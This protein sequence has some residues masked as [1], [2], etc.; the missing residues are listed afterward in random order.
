MISVNAQNEP[1]LSRSSASKKPALKNFSIR[2]SLFVHKVQSPNELIVKY[3]PPGTNQWPQFFR[4]LTKD[5]VPVVFSLKYY[6]TMICSHTMLQALKEPPIARA[7]TT[8][9]DLTTKSTV[10]KNTMDVEDV[11]E[12]MIDDSEI[13]VGSAVKVIGGTFWEVIEIPSPGMA[14]LRRYGSKSDTEVDIDF[15][16][17]VRYSHTIFSHI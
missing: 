12:R 7:K 5:A 17:H 8:A 3:V 15:L 13:T 14:L 2:A 6:V 1:I 11:G 4:L 10:K 9:P 16:T